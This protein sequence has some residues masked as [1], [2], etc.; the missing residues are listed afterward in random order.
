LPHHLLDRGGVF[1]LQELVFGNKSHNQLPV[2]SG[3]WWG[4]R[5]YLPLVW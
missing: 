2:V 3:Q 5:P 1:N 4:G